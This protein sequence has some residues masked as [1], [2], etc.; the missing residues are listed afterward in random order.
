M[1]NK[2]NNKTK[3]G[4]DKKLDA[5]KLE[6]ERLEKLEPEKKLNADKEKEG[7]KY[8]VKSAKEKGFDKRNYFIGGKNVLIAT[9]G[10]VDESTYNAFSDKAK[11]KFFE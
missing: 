9:G 4:A 2:N 11:E 10:E 5:E 1:A 6:K 3:A 8:K 7:K